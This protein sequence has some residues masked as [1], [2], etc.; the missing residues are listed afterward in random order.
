M[1]HANPAP[2]PPYLSYTWH[3]PHFCQIPSPWRHLALSLGLWPKDVIVIDLLANIFLKHLWWI[4]LWTRG[5]CRELQFRSVI[6]HHC[7][8]C[9]E[10][11]SELFSYPI[12]KFFFPRLVMF[13]KCL[14][15]KHII[16]CFHLIKLSVTLLK[17]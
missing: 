3:F 8:L 2:C 16:I 5:T 1:G 6:Y 7:W 4:T 9:L 14:Y 13:I 12:K 15:P 17:V 10:N 11:D